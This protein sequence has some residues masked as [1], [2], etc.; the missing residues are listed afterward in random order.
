MGDRASTRFEP[1]RL[2]RVGREVRRSTGDAL[3]TLS[4]DP[5]DLVVHGRAADYGPPGGRWSRVRA[6]GEKRSPEGN[7]LVGGG[8]ICPH[9]S[10]LPFL[11]PLRPPP[12]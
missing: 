5:L 10:P 8:R 4:A 7:P 2:C 11:F 9:P 6:T 1:L 12:E 3:P